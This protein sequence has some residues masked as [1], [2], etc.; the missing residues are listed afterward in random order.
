[1]DRGSTAPANANDGRRGG[2]GVDDDEFVRMVWPGIGK[3]TVK[4][5]F[6]SVELC[7]LSSIPN[8]ITGFTALL[9]LLLLLELP[10]VNTTKNTLKMFVFCLYF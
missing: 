10:I 1:M 7:S 9:I 4:S 5:S 2:P 8:T 6:Q 3:V